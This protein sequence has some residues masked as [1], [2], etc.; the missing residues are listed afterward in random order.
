MCVCVCKYKYKLLYRSATVVGAAVIITVMVAVED[1]AIG[2]RRH[3][4]LR[5]IGLHSGR[6]SLLFGISIR[7]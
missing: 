3:L 7:L 5:H 6:R 4:R 1:K 2:A